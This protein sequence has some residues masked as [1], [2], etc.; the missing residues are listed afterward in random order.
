MLNDM[1]ERLHDKIRIALEST[2]GLTQKGLARRM[3]LNPA[4][5]N[6]MLHGQRNVMAEELPIIEE[7]LGV[8]LSLSDTKSAE[9]N[10]QSPDAPMPR[11]PV[12]AAGRWGETIDW[13]PRH[14]I[15][16]GIPAAFAV[17][18]VS[19][20]MA[21]RYFKGELAYIH[22]SRPAETGRDCLIETTD[23]WAGV[24]RLIRDT[25]E[26][27]CV[28]QFNPPFERNISRNDIKSLYSV[29]GRG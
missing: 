6:R 26:G 1:T 5:V 19:D 2:R 4:A 29:I 12:Y 23:G 24:R 20:E 9:S 28:S 21:P 3:G 13:A 22:P 18:V 8:K 7:Y 10:T 16:T 14:P 11:I 25:Q 27:I 17:Y 15:Q